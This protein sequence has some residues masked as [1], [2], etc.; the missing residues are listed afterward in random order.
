VT[1]QK[2][3]RQLGVVSLFAVAAHAAALLSWGGPAARTSS[4]DVFRFSVRLLAASPAVATAATNARSVQATGPDRQRGEPKPLVA[5]ER[6]SLPTTPV[7]DA[8]AFAPS[9]AN[10]E[11][12]AQL[13]GLAPSSTVF[14]LRAPDTEALRQPLR[15]KLTVFIDEI[16][17]VTHVQFDSPGLSHALEEAAREALHETHFTP[18]QDAPG[19]PASSLQVE[20]TFEPADASER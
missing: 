5:T 6:P 9:S 7:R 3:R 15:A 10:E 20:V 2:T 19:G 1:P 18:A 12:A 11:P 17:R 16:G 4:A 8:H 13:T 14:R